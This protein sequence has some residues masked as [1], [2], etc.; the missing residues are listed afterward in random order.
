DRDTAPAGRDGG[1]GGGGRTVDLRDPA[2]GGRGAGGSRAPG[3]AGGG[4]SA[5]G[6]VSF[7]YA[8][9][10][11]AVHC[12]QTEL[13]CASERG[14]RNS[15]R[16][17]GGP[18][19]AVTVPR[20]AFRLPRSAR[21][22]GATRVRSWSRGCQALGPRP[23]PA[24]RRRGAPPADRGRV[25]DRGPHRRRAGGGRA[26]GRAVLLL[27]LPARPDRV[28]RGPPGLP[29]EDPHRSQRAAADAAS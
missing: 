1:E 10:P 24:A 20:F 5:A 29:V 18:D 9:G 26:D 3:G 13:K 25:P 17:T 7:S 19:S 15:E 12:Y 2:G 28:G 6:G 27:R 23:A 11:G 14:T 21:F 8:R 4:P 16:G 22:D